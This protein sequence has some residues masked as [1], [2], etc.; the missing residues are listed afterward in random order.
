M[1]S[2][3]KKSALVRAFVFAK[4]LINFG[5]GWTP[6]R[7]GFADEPSSCCERVQV[8]VRQGRNNT[9]NKREITLRIFRQKDDSKRFTRLAAYLDNSDLPMVSKYLLWQLDERNR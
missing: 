3:R 9:K 7:N 5:K 4:T 1:P 6:G 2:N 8:R